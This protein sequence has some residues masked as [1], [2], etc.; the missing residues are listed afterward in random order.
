[1]T[2]N[3]GTITG[4]DVDL[5]TLLP[6]N[7]QLA[8]SE[9]GL[10]WAPIVTFNADG[11]LKYI[12][13][14]SISSSKG[15][16]VWTI[17]F[18][19]GW[20]FHNGEPVTAQS[21]AD[22]WNFSAY[23]PNGNSNGYQLANIVGYD[24][25]NPKSGK[26]SVKT[27]SGLKV[28][29]QDTL[30]VTLSKPDSQFPLELGPGQPGFYPMPK[31]G[32][33]NPSTFKTQPIGDGPYEMNGPASLNQYVKLKAFPGYQGPNKAHVANIEFKLYS[34]PDTAW[35]DAQAGNVDIDL[36]PQDKFLQIKSDFGDRVVTASGAS[37]EFLGFPLFDKKFQNIKLREAISE[38][39][40]RDAINKAIFG[41]IYQPADSLFAEA[42]IG[43]STHACQ[44]CK[45]D[46]TNAKKLLSE[47][48]GWTGPMTIPYP[49]GAGYDQAFQAV[50]NQIRQNLGIDAKAQPSVG[51]SDFFTNMSKRKYTGGPFRG[52]W[53]SAYPSPADTLNSLF[54][55]VGAFNDSVGFY[56]NPKVTS[57]IQQGNAA[58]TL[59]DAVKFYDNAER[60]IE[61][62]FPVVPMFWEK[63]PFVYSDKVTN[64]HDRPGLIDIDWED[65]ELK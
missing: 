57:L 47:A 63:F 7:T 1:V 34:S 9:I 5:D 39:I 51:F 65:V 44:Y 10:L 2:L 54:T 42:M 56:S 49:G 13:A 6:G 17:K 41:G 59:T 33:S 14:S 27:L 45:F 15:D 50:A 30:Q 11:S 46:P 38:S 21:Y 40:D 52:K 29:D 55:P 62:D 22:G 25:L 19:P 64:V 24:A 35:T 61:T 53:G 48:G 23:A 26:P 18:R 8:F 32:I 20:T 16:T 60:T 43:G 28:V 31:A 37:I 3:P 36:A 58:P 4:A 12:Q